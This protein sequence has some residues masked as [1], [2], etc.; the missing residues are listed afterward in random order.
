MVSLFRAAHDLWAGD[1]AFVTLV[2]RLSSECLEFAGWWTSHDVA[3]PALVL[4]CC[5]IRGTDRADYKAD[6]SMQ[7]FRPM[8]IVS[9]AFR[10]CRGTLSLIGQEGLAEAASFDVLVHLATSSFAYGPCSR[11]KHL[12]PANT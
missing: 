1:P 6:T 9:E 4:K 5:S 12:E 11:H 7:R 8:T 3:A 10:L 2:E